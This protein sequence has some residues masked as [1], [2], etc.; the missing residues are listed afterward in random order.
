MMQKEMKVL[1]EFLMCIHLNFLN[2][3]VITPV[4]SL[5]FVHSVIHGVKWPNKVEKQ[6]M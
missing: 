4:S 1:S 6:N 3:K 5:L 2:M